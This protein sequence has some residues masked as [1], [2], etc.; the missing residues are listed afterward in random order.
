MPRK[1]SDPRREP[2]HHP[3]ISDFSLGNWKCTRFGGSGRPVWGALSGGPGNKHRQPGC[4]LRGA[5]RRGRLHWVQ[6]ATLTPTWSGPT[7]HMR[8]LCLSEGGMGWR[9]LKVAAGL[10]TL[11]SGWLSRA[12]RVE[13]QRRP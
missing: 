12:P 10:A 7:L 5:H 11:G 1:V 3:L 13:G 6:I 8:D 2:A 4:G 9:R